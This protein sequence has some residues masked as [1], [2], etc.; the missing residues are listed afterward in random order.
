MC[1]KPYDPHTF[2]KYGFWF[3]T[4]FLTPQLPYMSSYLGSSRRTP[5]TVVYPPNTKFKVSIPWHAILSLDANRRLWRNC[6]RHPHTSPWRRDQYRTLWFLRPESHDVTPGIDVLGLRTS[7]CEHV[8]WEQMK[9]MF[10]EISVK[11]ERA[12]WCV[13]EIFWCYFSSTTHPNITSPPSLP[14]KPQ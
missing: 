12:K 9:M 13:S 8:R 10:W 4:H 11:E 1:Q 14:P 6:L 7:V 5:F 3:Y 2:R